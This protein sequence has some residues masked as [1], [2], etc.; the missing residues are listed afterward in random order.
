[1]RFDLLAEL[2]VDWLLVCD[3]L[4]ELC[5][6]KRDLFILKFLIFE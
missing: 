6:F 1:M 3:H 5:R 2:D 4:L